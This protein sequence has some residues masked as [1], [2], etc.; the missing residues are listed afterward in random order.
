MVVIEVRKVHSELAQWSIIGAYIVVPAVRKA[1]WAQQG[2]EAPIVQQR[3]FRMGSSGYRG[4]FGGGLSQKKPF[5]IGS[6]GYW[7]PLCLRLKPEKPIQ[8]GLQ[9]E[10]GP[11]LVLPEVKKANSELAQA[12]IG[13]PNKSEK[14]FRIGSSGNQGP[15]W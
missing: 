9:Q 1:E 14:P 4:P 10:S 7:G 15:F 12:G 11:P 5:R 13:G 2:T 6:T 3:P 8:N